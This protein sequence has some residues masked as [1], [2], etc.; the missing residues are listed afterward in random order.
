MEMREGSCRFGLWHVHV[1]WSGRCIHASRFSTVPLTGPVPVR[2]QRYCAGIREDLQGLTSIALEEGYP[3]SA[4]YRRV[5]EIPY[6][7][8]ETYGA[9]ARELGTSPRVIGLAMKRNP[10]P[11]VIPCHR[12]VSASG[13]GGFTPDPGIKKALLSMERRNAR[14][15]SR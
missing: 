4:V 1:Y 15:L 8:T 11:L 14:S 5:R 13:M 9:V 2:I 7:G 12:V 10:T 6:G 3:F